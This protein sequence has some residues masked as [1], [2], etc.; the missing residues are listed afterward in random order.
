MTQLTSEQMLA[1]DS[2][3]LDGI[4]ETV[5]ND[6]L[7]T[8]FVYLCPEKTEKYRNIFEHC[9]LN[10]KQVDPGNVTRHKF[11]V[12]IKGYNSITIIKIPLSTFNSVTKNLSLYWKEQLV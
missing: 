4:F 10:I 5:V 1:L 2:A 3:F 7:K 8:I 9:A 11:D 6:E 12:T